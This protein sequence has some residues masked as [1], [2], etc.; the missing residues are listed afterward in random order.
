[1]N[2]PGRTL[3]VAPHSDDAVVGAAS[4]IPAMHDAWVIHATDSAPRNMYDARRYGFDTA[5]DYAR[6]RRN[7]A[8][9]A[10]GMAGIPPEQVVELGFPDQEASYCL[11]EM[12]FRLVDHFL[13]LQPARI[14]A[15]AYEGGHP[16]HDAVAF[17][18]AQA[19][20]VSQ[21]RLGVRYPL[22][23]YALYH[24]GPNGT[25]CGTFLPGIASTV[26]NLE[27]D[28]FHRKTRLLD[29]FVT[30]R[31]TLGYLGAFESRRE[32]YR[33]APAYDFS[34][35]PHD[36]ALHYESFD[37]GIHG[38]RWRQQALTAAAR[39]ADIAPHRTV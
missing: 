23:E 14:L 30:Q 6:V 31:Q 33:P 16:D 4:Q 8:M 18:V 22:M 2:W 10:L 3:I 26:I 24:R 13:R 25:E 11:V 5:A 27:G 15:P 38:A 39:I 35:P 1:M 9:V 28:Q 37:W 36:G 21:R 29:C 7:E 20:A 19:L 32:A 12:T 34:R 17:A